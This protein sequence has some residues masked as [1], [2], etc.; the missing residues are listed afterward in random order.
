MKKIAETA[1]VVDSVLDE[2]VTVYDRAQVVRSTLRGNSVVGE[3]SRVD[4]C[5]FEGGCYIN[6]RNMLSQVTLGK[7]SYMGYNNVV[8]KV[9]IGRFCS[10][11]W[12][13]QHRRYGPLYGLHGSTYLSDWWDRA[14]GE[15]PQAENPPL[16]AVAQGVIGN[17]VWIGSGATLLYGVRIGD[18]A[19]IGAGAVVTRDVPPYAVVAGVPARVIKMRFEPEIIAGLRACR[20][21]ELPIEGLREARPILEQTMTP[22]NLERLREVCGRY[23]TAASDEEE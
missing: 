10:M 23:G 3:D 15:R 1:T 22:E 18:G 2:Q 21:W 19:V 11:A 13:I 12:N 5:F 4:T 7:Y 16:E 6:R 9:R 14:L 8:R 17:D 20:W